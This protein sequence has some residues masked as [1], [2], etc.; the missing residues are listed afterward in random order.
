MPQ[1]DVSTYIAQ[2]FW[3]ITT[4]LCF[5]FIMDKVIIPKI[6]ST[7]DE[8]KRKYDELIIKAEKINKK[9]KA[10]LQKYEKTIAAAKQKANEQI[11]QNEKEIE[12]FVLQK[13][14]EIDIALKAKIKESEL[15]LDKN[16]KETMQKIDELSQS[17]ALSILEHL[18]LDNITIEDIKK[19]S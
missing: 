6:T 17:T 7:M 3:L 12:A 4:F 9:A 8:R 16:L 14:N 13:E 5:W 1:F 2:I 19:V 10:S 18:E 11:K 15:L